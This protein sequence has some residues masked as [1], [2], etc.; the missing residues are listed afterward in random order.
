[1]HKDLL[2]Y[3]EDYSG[4]SLNEWE[5]KQLQE[6]FKFK[7]LRKKQ[8]LLQEGDIC[9][10]LAFIVKGA[11]RL[12]SVDEDG[13]DVTVLLGIENWWMVDRESHIMLTPATYNIEAVEDC[14]LLLVTKADM[15]G[16]FDKVPAVKTMIDEL[17][18]RNYIHTQRKM[19]SFNYPIEKRY[20][21]WL[22]KYP[23][24]PLRFPQHMIASFLGITPETLSRVRK[25]LTTKK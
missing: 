14:E 21:E 22:A 10:H 18:H 12:F 23:S 16:L 24:F 13:K 25:G 2:N 15:Y 17:G 20:T 5:Y 9:I 8:F 19:Q 11:M 1:M 6:A 7:K 3:I 4:Q